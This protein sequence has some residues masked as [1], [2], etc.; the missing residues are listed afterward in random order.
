MNTLGLKG[1]QIILLMKCLDNRIPKP[2]EKLV[3]HLMLA[4]ILLLNEPRIN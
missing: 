2:K 4:F 3:V 1:V